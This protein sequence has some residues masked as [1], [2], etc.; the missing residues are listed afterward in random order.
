MIGI[1]V[2]NMFDTGQASRVLQ[3][4]HFSLAYLLQKFCG[5]NAQKQYQLA[6]WRQ[7]PLSDPMIRYAREDTHYLLFIYDSIRSDLTKYQQKEQLKLGD[8]VD[9]QTQ[10]GLVLEKSKAIC[11]KT[12][13]KPLFYTKGIYPMFSLF[14]SINCSE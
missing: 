1:Y 12:Y 3:Y 8:F 4:P 11:K 5:I 2:V 6:D 14:F 10:I 9:P 7:R 13:K